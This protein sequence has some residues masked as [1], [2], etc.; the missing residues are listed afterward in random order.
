VNFPRPSFHDTT[1]TNFATYYISTIFNKARCGDADPT[2]YPGTVTK[3]RISQQKRRMSSPFV[4]TGIATPHTP[5]PRHSHRCRRHHHDPP[6]YISTTAIK[7]N[8]KVRSGEQKEGTP[9]FYPDGGHQTY[10][11]KKP[12]LFYDVKFDDGDRWCVAAM[13]FIGGW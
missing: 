6:P 5:L 11:W 12:Q 3:V 9:T 8:K 7:K 10:D 2:F 13:G 4:T 1:I